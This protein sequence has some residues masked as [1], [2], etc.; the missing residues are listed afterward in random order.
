MRS[1]LYVFAVACLLASAA[2]AQDV[3]VTVRL[4]P[5]ETHRVCFGEATINGPRCQTVAGPPVS[6]TER[7]AADAYDRRAM[8]R[9]RTERVGRREYARKLEQFERRTATAEESEGTGKAETDVWDIGGPEVAARKT[10][11]AAQTH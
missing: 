10:A 11:N 4:H 9:Q 2:S 5:V 3:N 7:A 1:R 8:A 6:S